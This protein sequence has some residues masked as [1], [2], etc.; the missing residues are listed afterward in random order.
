VSAA[1]VKRMRWNGRRLLAGSMTVALA[2]GCAVT[3]WLYLTM[4]RPDQ[5]ASPAVAETAVQAASA[6]TVA[7]LSYKPETVKS[8]FA[9]AKEHLTGEFLNYYDQFTQQVV[10]PA[11]QEKGVHATAA[12]VHAAVSDLQPDSAVVLLFVNQSTSSQQ[13]PEQSMRASSVE[14]GLRKVDENWLISAFDPV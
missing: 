12:V 5:Q 14:V 8:D 10:A 7:V 6:G 4:Y 3:A 1:S 13:N 11:V 9:A 2:A